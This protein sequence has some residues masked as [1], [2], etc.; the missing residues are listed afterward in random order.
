M[1]AHFRFKGFIICSDSCLWK[2]NNNNDFAKKENNYQND[3]VK[4]TWMGIVLGWVRVS[5]FPLRK[6]LQRLSGQLFRANGPG[7]LPNEPVLRCNH[8]SQKN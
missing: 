1:E 3:E 6:T 4:P 5:N 7:S 8:G 2:N